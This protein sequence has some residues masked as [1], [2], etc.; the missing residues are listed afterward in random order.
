M[1]KELLS[2]YE[3]ASKRVIVSRYAEQ[4]EAEEKRK[5]SEREELDALPEFVNDWERPDRAAS[6]SSPMID[7]TQGPTKTYTKAEIAEHQKKQKQVVEKESEFMIIAKEKEVIHYGTPPMEVHWYGHFTS[8]SGFSRLNRAM[9][10]GLSNRNMSVKL[11]IQKTT[12]DINEAT[13]K[14]LSMLEKQEISA[15]AP[16]V[17]GATIPLR[18][19]HGGKKILYTMMETSETLHEGYVGRINLYDEVWVPTEHGMNLF[20]KN[21][22]HPPIK[23]MPLGVDTLRYHPSAKPMKFDFG[24]KKFVFLSVFKWGYRKGYDILL[25]AFLEEFSSDDDVSLLI[26]SRTDVNHKPEQIAQDF[27][28][29]RNG[30]LKDDKDLPHIALYDKPVKERDMPKIYAASD[31]FV[32]IS[33]GEGFCTLPSAC[34]KCVDGVKSIK[35][36]KVGDK[37]FSHTGSQRK[38][39]HKFERNYEGLMVKLES[40]GRNNQPLY[41][42]PNHKVRVL[43]ID[44]STNTGLKTLNN[45]LY[46]PI[47]DNI[48]I[49]SNDHFNNK[50]DTVQLEWKR[51]DEIKKGDYLFYPKLDYS[52][53]DYV[54]T[55]ADTINLFKIDE[56]AKHFIIEDGNIFKKGRNQ[57]GPY[58]A[59]KLFDKI[60][61]DLSNDFFK[62]MGYFVAEG[63]CNKNE[64]I[65]SFHKFDK[66]YHAEVILLMENVFGKISYKK[67][68]HQTKLSTKIVFQSIIAS[69]LFKVLFSNGESNKKLPKFIICSNN[70]SKYSFLN[71]LFNGDGHYSKEYKTSLST[72]SVNLAN[73]IFDILFSMNI[74]ST[75]KK[76][77]IDNK[78]YYSVNITNTRDCNKLL[79]NIDQYIKEED[80]I[81]K[82]QYRSFENFQLLCVS[83]ISEEQYNGNVYNIGVEI[84]NSYICENVAVHNCLPYY[85]AAAS[86]L[87]II[88]SN[89]SGQSDLLSEEGAYLV[90]P[91]SYSTATI[92]GNM[93]NLAKHCGFYENQTFPDFGRTSIEQTKTH[94]RD[95]IDDYEGAQIKS[96]ILGKTVRENFTWDMAIDKVYNRL[97]EFA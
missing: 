37:V 65:F 27:G 14:E 17:Y 16:K 90:E 54:Y 82:S 6:H 86:G 87:P 57:Y 41:L 46:D 23:V 22:V 59:Q 97:Q 67:Y 60:T 48:K 78:F 36:I 91:D 3:L 79:F 1:G 2:A 44:T 83:K 13:Q 33:R 8:Y 96:A 7:E 69:K 21:G 35:D 58:K 34:I 28:N 84:D 94:M 4:C 47:E 30:I 74:K 26:V 55:C 73:D 51:A 38:V 20:K 85:E 10:F 32:L 66:T 18:L 61:I 12:V 25:K 52:L 64:V 80:D 42:T 39:T 40:I 50:L 89:C 43:S 31:A 68:D 63:C 29:V 92:G 70:E 95:I 77:L 75:I 15:S 24:L 56:F 93:S 81:N 9:A 49:Y 71:G 72:A 45:I 62:L 11:D 88:G 53:N 19:A 5:K 76:R